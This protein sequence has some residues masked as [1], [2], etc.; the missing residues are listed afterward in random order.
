MKKQ[1]PPSDGRDRKDHYVPQG[2]LRGFIHPERL[3]HS[4]PLHVFDVK[5]REWHEKAPAQIA[6]ER[7]FYDYSPE[8]DP[9][10][11]ADDAFRRLE[12]Q[13]PIVRERIRVEGYASWIEHHELLVSFAAMMAARSPLFRTQSTCQVLH[14]LRVQA[15][16]EALAK[17]YSITQ[18]RTEIERRRTEWARFH[19][20]LGVATRPD[21]PFV[22][23]DQVVGMWGNG[24]GPAEAY[25]SNDFWIWC[26]ISWDMCLIGSSQPLSGPTTTELASE[27]IAEVQT[28]TRRQ[29]TVFV[30]SPVRL[31]HLA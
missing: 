17:N 22:T 20:V 15:N 21:I 9:D 23:S 27:H 31:V 29:A 28:L 19:W 16:G 18:M 5:R 3:R 24:A 11:T 26:P 13:L 12:N 1:K 2:Y 10:A 4:K 6:W 8:S 14:S 7:G 30:A 25:S